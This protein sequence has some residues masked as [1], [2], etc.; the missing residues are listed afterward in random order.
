MQHQRSDASAASMAGK[1]YIVGGFNGN[2]VLGSAEIYDP[3]TNQWTL[4]PN[5]TRPRSGVQLV[6]FEERYLFAIGGNDGTTRQ[7]SMERYDPKAKK[8]TVMAPMS[9]P[10]SNF[11]SVVLENLIYVI[12]GFNVRTH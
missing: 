12:G 3:V 6:P 8:W 7:T 4:I 10:R 11:S 9:I 5:M 1:V 2:E